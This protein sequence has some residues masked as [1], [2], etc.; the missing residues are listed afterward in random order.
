VSA[1]EGLFKEMSWF[2]LLQARIAAR[3]AERAAYLAQHGE[4]PV[5]LEAGERW[6]LVSPDLN[7]N[8]WRLTMFDERGP[9]GHY[10]GQTWLRC[11]EI[12]QDDFKATIVS[13]SV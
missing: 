5:R 3:K 2:T 7:G 4:K 6:F 1:G 10:E 11:L 12:A 13:R 8:G 9:F